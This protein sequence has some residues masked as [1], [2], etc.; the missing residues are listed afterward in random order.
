MYICIFL[1]LI[2]L[3]DMVEYCNLP[4][5]AIFRGAY[6]SKILFMKTSMHGWAVTL[7][8][9]WVDGQY[10]PPGVVLEVSDE[11]IVQLVDDMIPGLDVRRL[12]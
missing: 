9:A 1:G 3:M 2:F 7:R 8:G 6:D 12:L 4:T 11:E 5:G 10:N